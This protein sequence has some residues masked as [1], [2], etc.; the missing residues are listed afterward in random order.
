MRNRELLRQI[1]EDTKDVWDQPETRPAARENFARMLNCRTAALGGEVYVSPTGEKKVF[2]HTCKSRA[3]PSCGYRA[4]LL[5]QEEMRAALPDIGYAGVGFTMPN[6]LWPIFKQNRHLLH[7]LPA[8]GAEVIQQW[9]KAKYGV[10]VLVIVVPHTFGAPLNFN[11]HLHILASA[12]G[13]QESKGLWIPRIHFPRFGLMRM[14]KY[15]VIT[16]LRKALKANVLKSDADT[17]ELRRMLE[18]QYERDWIID[19]D[20]FKSKHHF[21]GYAARYLRR[22]P[23]AQRRFV[24]AT[25]R[26]VE[27]LTKDKKKKQVVTTRYSIKEFIALL[28][29]HVPDRYRHAIRYF[30]L[31][32]PGTK[33]RTSAALFLLLGQQKRPRPRRLSW[34]FLLRR[35]FGVDPL[36][37]HGGQPMRW[38]GRLKPAR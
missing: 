31:L 15:A 3:C 37:D 33:A 5:W 34:A 29:E 17:K 35:H 13:L 32:A 23:I 26:E 16:Y 9:A 10:R 30:G 11:C 28:A 8:L 19:V 36:I 1:L 22:P 20:H 24:K 25:D 7:D 4:T 38:V 27:F 21:L 18:T 12:G 14:W 6:V 2:Y